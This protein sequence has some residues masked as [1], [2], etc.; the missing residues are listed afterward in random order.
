MELSRSKVFPLR[1]MRRD[2]AYVDV[3][4][5]RIILVRSTN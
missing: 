5:V 3:T 2:K 4:I 1:V